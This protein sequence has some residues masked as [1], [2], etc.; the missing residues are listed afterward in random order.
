MT[1]ADVAFAIC[2][3]SV[4]ASLI[5]FAWDCHKGRVAR[6]LRREQQAAW[7]AFSEARKRGDTR[8]QHDAA[9]TAREAT[10]APLRREVGR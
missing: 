4:P 6:R 1:G 7:R 5:A 8:G 3:L 2:C 10:T 9:L